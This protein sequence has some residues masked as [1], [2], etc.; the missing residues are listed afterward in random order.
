MDEK[1][2]IYPEV[3]LNYMEM[4]RD[5]RRRYETLPEIVNGD[6]GYILRPGQLIKELRYR[7]TNYGCKFH[8]YVREIMEEGIVVQRW[9][10]EKPEF[11]PWIYELPNGGV[12]DWRKL[13][14]VPCDELYEKNSVE[15]ILSGNIRL[16]NYRMINGKEVPD[17][18]GEGMWFQH[19]GWRTSVSSYRDNLKNFVKVEQQVSIPD[20]QEEE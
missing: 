10:G 8:V 2:L 4:C 15:D 12:Y 11:L 5:G 16:E 9:M 14:I 19:G 20:L 7:D 18:R 13:Y 3:E 6:Y 17:G 1:L